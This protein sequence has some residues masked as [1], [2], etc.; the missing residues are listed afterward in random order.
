MA[1]I[2]AGKTKCPLCHNVIAQNDD[3]MATSHLIGDQNDPLWAYSDAAMHRDCF[4]NWDQRAEFVARF[5][6]VYGEVTF[7]NGTYHFME[8]D[9][10]IN[11]LERKN[12]EALK[13][14]ST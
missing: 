6:Q 2:F 9:G 1:L 7:G 14:S 11:V 8:P 13:E 4:L 12:S 10:S 3:Y 5:N